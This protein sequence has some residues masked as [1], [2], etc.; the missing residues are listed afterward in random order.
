MFVKEMGG[1]LPI[2]RGD[3]RV[4]QFL[5]KASHFILDLSIELLIVTWNSSQLVKIYK[6]LSNNKG[7]SQRVRKYA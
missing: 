5:A 3:G 2:I 4:I 1:L 6:G 7:K